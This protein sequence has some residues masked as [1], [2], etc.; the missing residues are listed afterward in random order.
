M[1][2]LE[3]TQT[4][5]GS[6]HLENLFLA[7]DLHSILPAWSLSGEYSSFDEGNRSDELSSIA[8][9]FLLC[10]HPNYGIEVSL[11]SVFFIEMF[12]GRGVLNS[13]PIGNYWLD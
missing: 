3:V 1:A 2:R 5:H 7:T 9:D 11:F 6:L 4:V 13:C 10:G 12:E 8:S